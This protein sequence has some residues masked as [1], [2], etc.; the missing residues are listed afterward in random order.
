MNFPA[1]FLDDEAGVH[2]EWVTGNLGN[3][4]RV[5]PQILIQSLFCTSLCQSPRITSSSSSSEGDEEEANSEG[6]GEP[7]GQQEQLSS[8][9]TN[10]PPPSYNH[11]QVFIQIQ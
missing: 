5:C 1:G 11:Q 9:K 8:G 4:L 10:S 3:V 7:P 2:Y 6:G